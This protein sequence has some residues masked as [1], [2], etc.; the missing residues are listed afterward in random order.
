MSQTVHKTEYLS[1]KDHSVSGET[2]KLMYNPELEMLETF[3][4]PSSKLLPKYYQSEDY[5]SHTD[6]KRNLFEQTYHFVKSIALK[7]KLKLINSIASEG[8]ELLDIGCGTGD[9]LQIAQQNNW[10]VTGTEP[11]Q[12]ARSIA[13]QKTNSSVF[14]ADQ[15]QRFNKNQFDVI[16]LWH[17]LEHLPN[18]PEQ[19][20]I[21]NWL[22]KPNGALIIAV[23]NYKSFDA[24]YYKTF[25]AAYD[26][27]RHFWHFSKSSIT[28]LASKEGMIVDKT[29]PMKFDA[30][31]VSLLSEKYKSGSMNV[32]RAFC[33]G[34]RSNFRARS[35]G[36]YSSLIYI[37]KKSKNEFRA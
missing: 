37:L 34:A 26:V 8:N 3:P 24:H 4:Q 32:F 25:W 18:L 20:A 9:F 5:I 27:P 10:N 30:F 28:K 31:Y 22:L 6:A 11:N 35:S 15:L 17:V 13:N 16:T 33:V 14:D 29:V 12:D 2:F 19:M 7:R 1:V 21:F 36:E 23:P